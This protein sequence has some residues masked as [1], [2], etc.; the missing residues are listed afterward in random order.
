MSAVSD[1]A[2]GEPRRV[3]RRAGHRVQLIAVERR[4]D[5]RQQVAGGDRLPRA[6]DRVRQDHRP[7][8]EET[9]ERREHAF[10]VRDFGAGVADALHH[11]A[12][13][14]G[15]RKEQQAADEKAE[16]A[17]AGP[18]A[19]QPVVHEDDPA[20]A[21]HRAEAEREVLDRA[22]AA[23]KLSHCGAL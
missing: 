11:P 21:D 10:G 5:A 1:E 6:H 14:V 17:A 12:V 3:D 9:G 23:A 15:D 13:G 22:Q 2:D 4:K 8:G 20:D 16:H 7:A 19:R 18:A